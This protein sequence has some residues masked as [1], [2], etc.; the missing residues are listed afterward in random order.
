VT[1]DIP[2]A[3]KAG[4]TQKVNSDGS[5]NMWQRIP[6]QMLSARVI[7]E[8]VRAVCPACLSG[9]YTNEEVADMDMT[10]AEPRNVTPEP[11]DRAAV[12][13]DMASIFK[14]GTDAEGKGGFFSA[15]EI[16]AARKDVG[17]MDAAALAKYRD[18]LRGIL[19]KRKDERTALNKV[20][21]AN[22]KDD[23]PRES[24]K[25]AEK[26]VDVATGEVR[27]KKRGDLF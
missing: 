4:Y 2:R 24:M 13:A 8:G 6:A 11:A 9:M 17:T 3:T 21:E 19:E 26:A 10:P 14:D 7:A 27:E 18:D 1:W 5:P 22:F 20:A 23:D 15:E 12:L 25:P 16:Q